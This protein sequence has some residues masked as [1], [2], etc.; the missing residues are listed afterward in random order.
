MQ[1]DSLE[2]APNHA[3]KLSYLVAFTTVF[4]VANVEER[5]QL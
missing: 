2:A 5:Y 3:S 1:L 4:F